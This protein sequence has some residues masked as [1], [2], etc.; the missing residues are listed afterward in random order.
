MM[1][2]DQ[3]TQNELGFEGIQCCEATGVMTV[4]FDES[5]K[6]PSNI[7]VVIDGWEY[8]FVPENKKC[9]QSKP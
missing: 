7:Y 1:Y 3:V 6:L 2:I 8:N 5:R 4:Y 9:N